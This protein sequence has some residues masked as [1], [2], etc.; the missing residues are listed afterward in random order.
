MAPGR[1]F[2]D[3]STE[4]ESFDIPIQGEDSRGRSS[5]E[6]SGSHRSGTGIQGIGP[7]DPKYNGNGAQRTID[8]DNVTITDDSSSSEPVLLQDQISDDR[9]DGAAPAPSIPWHMRSIA[10]S[11]TGASMTSSV[12]SHDRRSP[13]MSSSTKRMPEFFSPATFQAV[14]NNPTV[15]HQFLK[16][17]ESRLCGENLAFLAKVSKYRGLLDEVSKAVYEIH[18]QFIDN[19]SADQI[20]LPENLHRG[21]NKGMKASLASTI[22]SLEALFVDSQSHIEDLVYRDVYRKFVQHQMSVS[23][24]KALGSDKTKYAG[25]GDCFVLTDPHKVGI[26]SQA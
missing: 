5:G 21:V 25:L 17:S 11:V 18:K 20:N 26:Y 1:L 8:E 23:A 22:P 2:R 10:P 13:S 12:V 19:N 15:S 14:L 3:Y 9:Y 16:F 6:A 4:R 24:A 7:T